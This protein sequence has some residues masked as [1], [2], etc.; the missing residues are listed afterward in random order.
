MRNM[1]NLRGWKSRW[2]SWLKDRLSPRPAA[3]SLL[4][5]QHLGSLISLVTSSSAIVYNLD[6]QA[7]FVVPQMSWEHFTGQNWEQQQG[8]G[9]LM[10]LHAEDRH[11]FLTDF[12]QSAAARTAF[13]A[14]VRLWN[15]SEQ[16]YRYVS[17]KATPVWTEQT[18]GYLGLFTD[19]HERRE[20]QNYQGRLLGVMESSL[21]FVALAS[22]EGQLIYLNEAGRQAVGLPSADAVR[23]H[24]M[25]DFFSEADR[26]FFTTHVLPQVIREGRWHGKHRLH[27]LPP[28]KS[29]PV[30]STL[31]ATFGPDQSFIGF[32]CIL[33]DISDEQAAQEKLEKAVAA[34][35]DFLSIASHELKTPLTSLKLQLQLADRAIKKNPENPPTPER[36]QRTVAACLLQMNHLTS[37][38][39]DLLDV[40]RISSGK[41]RYRFEAVDVGS[42]VGE[43][44]GRLL[45]AYQQAGA[46]LR[47]DAPKHTQAWG[48]PFRI[49]Q[50]VVNLLTNA[51]KYGEKS[52]VTVQVFPEDNGVWVRVSDSGMG[53]AE[54]NLK[55]IFGRFERAASRHNI[56][57]LGL[58]LYICKQIVDA[59]HG[60]IEVDSELGVGTTFRVFL[61]ARDQATNS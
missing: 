44:S 1:G 34:R 45:P 25:L 30:Q 15:Q 11:R 53:I 2:M 19:E 10:A 50:V 60:R 59:H 46:V 32:G 21:E 51:L 13:V 3:P 49:E 39:E 20:R 23:D 37:L 38:V 43:I 41:M 4:N 24:T 8:H 52:T 42:L 17:T 26:P 6:P 58:G 35:D 28:G 48:D 54:A 9:W 5:P 33:R 56:S 40:S 12:L 18:G 57:G 61:H 22:A 27:P 47:V 36:M 14:E 31:F 55:K 16:I 29:F 7:R